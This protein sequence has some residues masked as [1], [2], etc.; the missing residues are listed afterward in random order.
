MIESIGVV[1]AAA[2]G[3]LVAVGQILSSR[4]KKLTLD[5]KVMRKDLEIRNKQFLASLRLIR[6]YEEQ[7]ARN[8]LD[9]LARPAELAEDY[10]DDT[11]DKPQGSIEAS[12]A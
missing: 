7:A 3:L 8:G 6:R 5:S 12:N 11:K 9:V 10:G 2:T 4:Q 1:M